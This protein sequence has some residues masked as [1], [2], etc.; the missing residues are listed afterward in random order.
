[1][2]GTLNSGIS[3]DRIES[4]VLD[5]PDGFYDQLDRAGR[6]FE[7][8]EVR[9]LVFIPK[10]IREKLCSSECLP[11]MNIRIAQLTVSREIDSNLAQILE[12]LDR[13]QAEDWVVF[14]EAVVSGYAPDESDYSEKLDWNQLDQHLAKIKQATVDAGCRTLVGS[15]VLVDEGWRNSVQ[16]FGKNGDHFQHHKRELS[17]LDQRHFTAGE[18]P[19]THH[20]DGI[21]IGVLACRELLFPEHWSSLRAQG[22]KVIFHLNNAIQPKDAIWRHLLISRAI[23]NAAFVVS[24]NNADHPQALPSFVIAP[25]GSIL[26]ETRLQANEVLTQKIDLDSVVNDLS[27]RTDF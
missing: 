2:L 7:K 19:E 27:E 10:R 9:A 15:A 23:E 24:V 20:V 26:Q 11:A 21:K 4:R 6:I 14:P 3:V 18:K 13:S 12:I 8:I 17:Q 22:A 25:D 5:E 1:M 16:I